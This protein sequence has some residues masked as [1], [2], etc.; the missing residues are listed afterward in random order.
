MTTETL[1]KEPVTSLLSLNEFELPPVG[2]DDGKA[3]AK[4]DGGSPVPAEDPSPFDAVADALRMF[5]DGLQSVIEA[6]L[7]H[8]APRMGFRA[9]R[10]REINLSPLIVSGLRASK[11]CEDI[12]LAIRGNSEAVMQ[13]R[14][15]LAQ[16]HLAIQRLL[17]SFSELPSHE[18]TPGDIKDR[19]IGELHN[20]SAALAESII[21]M[22]AVGFGEK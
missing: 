3:I 6:S 9:S 7:F 5:R 20:T 4:D 11:M 1:I 18:M 8:E 22:E 19:A 10:E 17:I 12:F 14:Q 2:K 13:T 15:V 21:F 16:S